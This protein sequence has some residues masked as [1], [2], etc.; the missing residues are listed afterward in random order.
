VKL[1]LVSGKRKN[2][3]ISRN[4]QYGECC[5]FLDINGVFC[6]PADP[7]TPESGR[8]AGHTTCCVEWTPP[9]DCG[10]DRV[11][12]TAF[13]GPVKRPLGTPS[14][15]YICVRPLARPFFGK[16][17]PDFCPRPRHVVCP[18]I[19]PDPA[20]DCGTVDSTET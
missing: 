19:R 20:R 7:T 6:F 16:K 14:R 4:G 1:L 13:S 5:L 18:A 15:I 2:P 8:M 10:P 11:S 3:F 9:D 17:F 12:H